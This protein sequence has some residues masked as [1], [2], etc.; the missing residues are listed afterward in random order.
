MS[1]KDF[2]CVIPRLIQQSAR[3]MLHSLCGGCV[4]S[5]ST[6]CVCGVKVSLCHS[7][8]VFVTRARE[9]GI[10]VTSFIQSLIIGVGLDLLFPPPVYS[11]VSLNELL[12]M[13]EHRIAYRS[14][15]IADIISN[16]RYNLV[17]L[18]LF[19]CWIQQLPYIDV[20]IISGFCEGVGAVFRKLRCV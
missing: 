10:L 2:I 13:P 12:V 5:S 19:L 14:T 6:C 11:I 18:S 3:V 7:S 20:L 16:Y 4:V 1:C 15:M 8:T 17:F 9:G